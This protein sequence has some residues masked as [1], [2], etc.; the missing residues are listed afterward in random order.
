MLMKAAIFYLKMFFSFFYDEARNAKSL[1]NIFFVTHFFFAR[2]ET[3]V[4]TI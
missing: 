3:T 2:P 1:L 4:E